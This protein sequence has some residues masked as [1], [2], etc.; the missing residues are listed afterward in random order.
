MYS[1]A[2][3]RPF[4]LHMY[5]SNVLTRVFKQSQ[6]MITCELCNSYISVVY[7][8]RLK[9]T[10]KL[11]HRTSVIARKCKTLANDVFNVY[12]KSNGTHTGLSARSSCSSMGGCRLM[13]CKGTPPCGGDLPS[14]CWALARQ[15]TSLIIQ[16]M[17][18]DH[19]CVMCTWRLTL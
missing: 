11:F 10:T 2:W 16:Q 13:R 1:C 12:Y 5:I 8:E 19:A 15:R 7:S 18:I 17:M 9:A 6:F 4:L 14:E 3:F